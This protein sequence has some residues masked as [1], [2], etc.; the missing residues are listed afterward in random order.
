MG[1]PQEWF[2]GVIA[3]FLFHLCP[4]FRSLGSHDAELTDAELEWAVLSLEDAE[5]RMNS[6]QFSEAANVLENVL[7][8]CA[9]I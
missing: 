1:D 9:C 8:R 7:I 6:L 4:L 3:S 5:E 2:K